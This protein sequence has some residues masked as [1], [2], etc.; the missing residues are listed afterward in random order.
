MSLRRG[1]D[2]RLQ[3]AGWTVTVDSPGQRL[4]AAPMHGW[5]LR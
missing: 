3:A 5:W 1:E 2:A 4:P